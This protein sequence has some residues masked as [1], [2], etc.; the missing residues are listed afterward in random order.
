MYTFWSQGIK[1][2]CCACFGSVELGFRREC[3]CLAPDVRY[4]PYEMLFFKGLDRN[5]QV[6]AI[7]CLDAQVVGTVESKEF[8]SRN[9]RQVISLFARKVHLAYFI[10]RNLVIPVAVFNV[11]YFIADFAIRIS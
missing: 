10:N 4:Q 1:K 11:D 5:R 8:Y 9:K 2:A 7:A 6:L 3:P